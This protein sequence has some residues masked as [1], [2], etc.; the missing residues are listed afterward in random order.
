[1]VIQSFG[2]FG[3]SLFFMLSG[4]VLAASFR[5]DPHQSRTRIVGQFLK[6]R[7][8]KIYP[9]YLLALIAAIALNG[10]HTR[11]LPLDLLMLQSWIPVSEYY[12]SGNAVSWFVSSLFFAYMLFCPLMWALTANARRFI[13]LFIVGIIVYVCV[14][15][16]TP[17]E[18][19]TGV[20]YVSPVM[21]LPAFVLG[22]LVW[23]AFE[24]TREYKPSVS[25]ISAAQIVSMAVPVILMFV[26][27]YVDQRWALASYWWIPDAVM[28][29]CLLV[30]EEYDTVI[31]RMLRL[32]IIQ[33]IGNISFVFYLFHTTVIVLYKYV[34]RH[35]GIGIP[36][37]ASSVVCLAITLTIA[38]ILHYRVELPIAA[39][40]KKVL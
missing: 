37:P 39:R 21:Q 16:L 35:T 36:M 25:L 10:C 6:K 5:Y 19:L 12:F 32:K 24:R 15:V 27:R 29:Y 22:M 18:Y 26:Y 11:A 2:D 14:V 40:L 17:E 4:L 1:M 28:L 8:I 38:Y 30:A 31:N 9:I 23:K 33:A 3:V 7:I 13:R 20:I 34:L